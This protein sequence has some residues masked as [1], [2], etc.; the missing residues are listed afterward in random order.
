[1]Q[2][3]RTIYMQGKLVY[4]LS[5]F[6]FKY[7]LWIGD[8]RIM[9]KEID[10]YKTTMEIVTADTI[11]NDAVVEFTNRFESI[12]VTRASGFQAMLRYISKRLKV[13]K[14]DIEA[15]DTLWDTYV[16][17]CSSCGLKQTMQAFSIMVDMHPGTFSDWIE[18]ERRNS[19]PRFAESA[20]RWKNECEN[21]LLIDTTE[22]NSI[23]SMFALKANY[24]YRDNVVINVNTDKDQLGEQLNADDIRQSIADKHPELIT[25]A[26]LEEI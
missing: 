20:K 16:L 22:R 7:K 3:I 25:D 24:G 2:A 11:I 13:N 17:V 21:A 26:D 1:M 18:G 14:A 15:L 8:I 6:A 4:S 12:D 9:G 10:T 19:A 23:G 5:F